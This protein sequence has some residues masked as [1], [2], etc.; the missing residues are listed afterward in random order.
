HERPDQADHGIDLRPGEQDALGPLGLQVGPEPPHDARVLPQEIEIAEPVLLGPKG[1]AGEDLMQRPEGGGVRGDLEEI[2]EM[3][4]SLGVGGEL[5]VEDLAG[6][7]LLMREPLGVDPRQPL[8]KGTER[9]G[10]L[11]SLLERELREP[12]DV[13]PALEPDGRLTVET[14]L[15]VLRE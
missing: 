10:V 4:R 6:E 1:E 11:L 3:A 13:E 8:A 2:P 9:R 12:R 7:P 15:V 14:E 5:P